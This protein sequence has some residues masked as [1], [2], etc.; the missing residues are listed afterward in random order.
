MDNDGGRK[1]WED[2]CV[3]RSNTKAEL[4]LFLPVCKSLKS[5][6]QSQTEAD[7]VNTYPYFCEAP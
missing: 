1:T 2:K 7:R 5:K 4:L 6:K 3:V